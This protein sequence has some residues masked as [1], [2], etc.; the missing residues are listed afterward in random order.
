MAAMGNPEMLSFA[1]KMAVNGLKDYC[2]NI[3]YVL[4][5]QNVQLML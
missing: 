4:T 1:L 5:M 3:V 2:D